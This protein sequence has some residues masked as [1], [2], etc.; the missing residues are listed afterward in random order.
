MPNA[1]DPH[2][3]LFECEQDAIIAHAE[4][5]AAC[6]ISM[7]DADV[8]D[9]GAGEVQN[10]FKKSHGCGAIQRTH[11]CPGRIE[12][13]DAIRRHLLRVIGRVGKIFRF[14]VELGQ[15]VCHRNTL[16]ALLAK[17]SLAFVKA[18]AVLFGY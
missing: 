14:E 1:K 13:I 8:A 15:H 17:P 5:G 16:P 12:P 18:A 10:A 3:V 11:I 4:P 7:K 6:H 9:A 2:R